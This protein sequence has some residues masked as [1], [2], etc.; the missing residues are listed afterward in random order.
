M[1]LYH[2][3]GRI[4]DISDVK[5][6]VSKSGY[7]WQR[8]TI[9]L[10]IPGFQGSVTKQVFN[11]TGEDV[12]DVLLFNVGDRVE[13]SW[14]LYAREW[15]GKWYNNADLVKIKRQEEVAPA[16]APAPAP[17]PPRQMEIVYNQDELDPET[18]DDLPF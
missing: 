5:S 6:G 10:E 12:D 8:L 9:I 18:H 4:A 3:I 1:A 16:P 14:S 7:Q 17:Q 2:S 13:V 15:N 11:V